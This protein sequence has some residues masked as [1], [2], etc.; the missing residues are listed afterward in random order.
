MSIDRVVWIDRGWQP[1]PIGFCPTEAAW[2]RA[3][4]RYNLDA[5]WPDLSTVGALTHMLKNDAGDAII[6]V[7]I[8]PKAERSALD[9]IATLVHEA[10]HVWQFLCQDISE[11]DP[12]I[13]MEAYGIE[14][15]SRG[16]I[17]AYCRTLGKGKN[18]IDTLPTNARPV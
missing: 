3:A 5:E 8:G 4:R 12:G 15:I 2:K 10:V 14:A 16:L 9:A 6:L 11:K 1:V 13:E 7:V 18:W 17:D